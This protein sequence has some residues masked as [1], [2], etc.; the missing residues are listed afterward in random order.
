MIR[1]KVV[2]LADSVIIDQTTN[3]VSLI[4]IN[5][6]FNSPGYPLLISR[7]CVFCIIERD[8]VNDPDAP[9]ANIKI[10]LDEEVI[11]EQIIE[12]NFQPTGLLNRNILNFLGFL[13]TRSGMLTARLEV[14]G[15][16]L[17]SYRLSVVPGPMPAPEQSH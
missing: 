8:T 9:A 10:R 11:F 14:A 7:L 4:N 13:L 12:V 5:E 1:P 16:I 15:Q 2:I 6:Q 17:D 3:R